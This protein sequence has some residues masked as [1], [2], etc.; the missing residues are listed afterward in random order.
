MDIYH[1]FFNL[2]EG[3]NDLAFYDD[4]KNFLD[5]LKKDGKIQ[6]WR[7][8]RRK[9][10]LGPS[11]FGEFHLMIEVNNLGQLDETFNLTSTRSGEVEGKHAFV[12]QKISSIKFALYRDFPDSNRVQGEEKF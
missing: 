5:F 6:S 4:L 8:M 9:L 7:L 3:E 1:S 2:K 10:G 11:E 12:N